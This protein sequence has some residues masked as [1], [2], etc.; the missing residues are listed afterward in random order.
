M[1]ES[2]RIKNF[3]CFSD[4]SVD[5]SGMTILTG[6]N[7]AGK[8]SVIQSI[9]LSASAVN[10]NKDCVYTTDVYGTNLGLA[11]KLLTLENSMEVGNSN[12][13][14]QIE[15][16]IEPDKM[17]VTLEVEERFEENYFNKKLDGS[18]QRDVFY[19]NAERIGP[20]LANQLTDNLA[21]RVGVHGENTSFML[22]RLENER[23]NIPEA[24][25]RGKSLRFYNN[26]SEWLNIIIPG[27]G[28]SSRSDSD[29][30]I[31]ALRYNQDFVPTTVGFGLTY[32][33][34]IIVQGLYCASLDDEL[35]KRAVLII[36]NPEA[37]LHPY[38]QSKIGSFLSELAIQGVQVI[39]ETHSEHVINGARLNLALKAQTELMSVLF[40][41]EGKAEKISVD[42]YGE[43]SH[44]PK[45]FFDQSM[46]DVRELIKNR[47]EGS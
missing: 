22:D 3:K 17:R 7:S 21:D 11:S 16:F 19:L 25:K 8:S 20:R 27:S 37:H 34:P 43:L 36:E 13:G 10:T 2:I 18:W 23:M 12:S 4:Y 24:L 1:L 28:F 5:F 15:F 14:N 40:F 38:S 47:M 45:G 30:G 32:V 33:L 31:S 44:W 41:D 9:L 29:L 26:C 35:K 46:Q 39:I 42:E 6:S